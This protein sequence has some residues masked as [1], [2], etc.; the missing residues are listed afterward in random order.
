MANIVEQINDALTSRVALTLST[1]YLELNYLLNVGLNNFGANAKRYGVRPLSGSST[2]GITRVY[3][4]DHEFEVILTHDWMPHPSS[5][6]DKRDKAFLMLD[7]M[8]AIIKDIFLSKATLPN[9][10]L[11]IDNISLDEPNYDIENLVV[12]RAQFNI[13]YRQDVNC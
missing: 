11:N 1:G 9:I 4:M 6:Q 10:I 7:K 5:D 8:D 3:T 13:K 2:S 12:L